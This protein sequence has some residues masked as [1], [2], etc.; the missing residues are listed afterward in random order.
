M[1]LPL[2]E[3]TLA[4]TVDAAKLSELFYAVMWVMGV[5]IL[6]VAMIAFLLRWWQWMRTQPMRLGGRSG[7]KTK[8]VDAWRESGKRIV[9][10]D[11]DQPPLE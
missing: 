7:Q 2:P 5:A 9:I 11:D 10:K 4:Q 6:G 8:Y 1:A 3:P